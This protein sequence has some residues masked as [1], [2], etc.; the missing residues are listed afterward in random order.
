MS[1]NMGFYTL[2]KVRMKEYENYSCIKIA[3]KKRDT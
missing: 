1:Y 3:E 2:L